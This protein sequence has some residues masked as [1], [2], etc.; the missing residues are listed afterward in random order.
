MKLT[1]FNSPDR[2]AQIAKVMESYFGRSMPVDRMPVAAANTM[3]RR[4]RGLIQEHKSTFDRHMSERN[5]VYLQLVMLEQALATHVKENMPAP[6][7]QPAAA[8]PKPQPAPIDP[9]KLKAA[10]D[11]LS[12]GQTL[13]PDEQKLVNAAAATQQQMQEDRLRRAF[14]TLKES[15]VQQAQV[16][17]A[18]QDMVDTIQGM[19]EDSTEMQYKELPALVD[20]IRNQ[21][22]LEQANQFNTDVTAALTG[23]VQNL[24]GTKQSFETALGVV[25][26]QAQPA[27]ALDAA[28]NAEPAPDAALPEP[29]AGA[30]APEELAAPTELEPGEE[31]A[32]GALGREK[33]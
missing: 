13:T 5:P 1:E 25:T 26:G 22:G 29:Q 15:E 10:Q 6:V 24:Q 30:E 11:K 23:L 21:I 20:S 18:A 3:L 9:N 16:V 4:V 32:A 2:L 17:L 28:M 7:T 14:R 31:P 12:K 33:R 27:P 19:I 8:Q